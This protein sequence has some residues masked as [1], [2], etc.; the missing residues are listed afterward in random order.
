MVAIVMLMVVL[1]IAKP[2]NNG[3]DA[4]EIAAASPP[5]TQMPAAQPA[6]PAVSAPAVSAPAA[7]QVASAVPP[8]GQP[9]SSVPPPSMLPRS[10]VPA[11][12]APTPLLTYRFN[13][14]EQYA[15][16]FQVKADIAGRSDQTSGMCTLTLSQAAASGGFAAQQSGQGSGSGFVVTPDG[17]IVTCAHVVE[18]STKLEAV[19]GAQTY[20]A[21][22]VAFDKEHDLAVIHVAAANL[23]TVPLA[24]SDTVQLAEEVRA[25]GYPLSNVL[26]E[27]VKI[28]RGTIAGVVNTSGQKLFQVDASIN[29]GNSGGPLVN[30][31]GQVVGVASAKLAREDVD[32]VGFVVP[33]ND[34][35]ALLRGKGISPASAAT[36]Q[37]LDG[38]TLAK[39]VTPAVALIKVTIGP[40]GYGTVNRLVLDFSGHV[41]TTGAPRTVGRMQMPGMPSTESDRGKLLLSERG[42]LLE[43]SG[44]VQLPFLLGPVGSLVLEPFGSDD[45][46]NWQTQRATVLTQIIGEQSNSP[47]GMRFRRRGRNPF[48]QSQAKVVVTPA[49]E[50]ASYDLTSMNA[51]VATITKRYTFQT[52]DPAGSPP[53]AKMTGE[54]TL[55]FNRAKGYAEKMEY[56]A[57]L[58]R[59]ASNVSVTI[60]MTLEWH[61]LSQAELDQMQAQAQASLEAAKKAQ[62][63]RAAQAAKTNIGEDTEFVGGTTGGGPKRTIDENSL[64]YGLECGF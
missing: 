53:T 39:R 34:V 63:E 10:P 50:S 3:G 36:A 9:V 22:V 56:K 42:E 12:A 4:A 26:G 45:K 52:L 29:P 49:L 7:N 8:P 41:T 24:N 28:T 18:G 43:A 48:G 15:Y 19:L 60:P 32:G 55:T 17:Y 11:A 23:P 16:R 14:G 47:F 38:P 27:S 35:L 37:K 30:E 21:Q 57:T 13:A 46:R 20:P 2:A 62:A 1:H 61:R 51:D 33:A 5:A 54:G 59:S 40:G 64:L 44:N 31:M 6:A 58:V 25:V